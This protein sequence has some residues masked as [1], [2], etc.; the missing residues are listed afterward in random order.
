MGY[1]QRTSGRGHGTQKHEKAKA[2]PK[3]KKHRFADRYASEQ[4]VVASDELLERTLTALH[5]LGNQIFAIPPFSQHFNRWLADLRI[6]MSE[7]ETGPCIS[8]DDQF[9]EERSEILAS[10]EAGFAER[11]RQ[12]VSGDKAFRNLSDD[13]ILVERIEKEYATGAKEIETRKNHEISR[14]SSSVEVLR[15][16]LDRIARMKT[17]IFR[18]L[19]KKAKVQREAETTQR[20]TLAQNELESALKNFASKQEKLRNEY[21]KRKQPVIQEMREDQK[22]IEEE[23]ID[24]SLE[25]RRVACEA[26]SNSVKSLSQRQNP[27]SL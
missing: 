13:R 26:L 17:G 24:S 9:A 8:V 15:E 4:T 6:V 18:G 10:V 25:A 22:Q 3:E 1:Q 12:E 21:E 16:E 14:L 19:S 27:S 2:R 20:L 11:R 5:N 7:F 23:E